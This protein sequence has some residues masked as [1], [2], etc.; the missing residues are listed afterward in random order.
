MQKH[1]PNVKLIGL[2]ATPFRTAEREQGLLAKIF[3]DGVQNEEVKRGH[4]GI[5]YQIGLKDLINR[6]IL[7]KPIF[8]SYYTEAHYGESLGLAA[9]ESIR[10]LDTLPD[11]IAQQM[12]KNAVRNRLIVDTYKKK[13]KEYGQT[14]YSPSTSTMQSHS[15]SSLQTVVSVL[16]TLYR[17]CGMVSPGSV[18]VG[19][20]TSEIWKHSDR[21]SW[22][23]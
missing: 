5:T 1:V 8:E 3:Q 4:V 10:H 18:S 20:K 13:R 16:L 22:M 11:D 21:E 17:Q 14:S 9:W 15:I 2:T 12:A 7:S 6:Q 23:Y 19:K